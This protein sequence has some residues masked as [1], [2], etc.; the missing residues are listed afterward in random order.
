[1]NISVGIMLVGL[2]GLVALAYGWYKARWILSQPV[3]NEALKR[4][5]GYV[6]D[7]AMA[8]LKRE[9]SVLVWFV[10]VV[11]IVLA[12]ANTGPL[13]WEAL[14]FVLGAGC[15][16]LAGFFGMKV[17]TAA[18]SRTTAAAN[19]SLNEALQVAFS[20]GSVMGMCVVGL[21]LVGIAIVLYAATAAFG[22]TPDVRIRLYYLFWL[23]FL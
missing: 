2:G 23:D 9:Y 4:I 16:G 3:E 20:G 10:G 21:A 6:A 1:M 11:A 5:S 8:F 13:R 19:R 15:S 14:A 17:A 18:N 12:V 22:S 7:G